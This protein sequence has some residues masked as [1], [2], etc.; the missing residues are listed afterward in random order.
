MLEAYVEVQLCVASEIFKVEFNLIRSARFYLQGIVQRSA[1]MHIGET[2]HFLTIDA[3]TTGTVCIDLEYYLTRL[4]RSEHTIIS[5]REVRQ[6]YARCKDRSSRCAEAERSGHLR[7]GHRI[8]FMLYVVP[9]TCSKSLSGCRFALA[10]Y[11][12]DQ[13]SFH[14]AAPLFIN[15]F[16]IRT[17]SLAYTA[18]NGDC[19][20]RHA[21]VISP[22]HHRVIGI[23]PHNGYG[24]P[25][26]LQRENIACVLK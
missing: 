26:T 17:Q 10:E 14:P 16:I 15:Q 20:R 5:R 1:A 8:A 3:Q 23:G 25:A 4:L 2:F 12:L 9:V 22:L 7:S 24:Q 19:V 21:V 13:C 11:T 6:V 18:Q